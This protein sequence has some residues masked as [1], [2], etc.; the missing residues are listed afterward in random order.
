MSDMPKECKRNRSWV[1]WNRSVSLA[2]AAQLQAGVQAGRGFSQLSAKPPGSSC[3]CIL[4]YLCSGGA[5]Q[6][7]VTKQSGMPCV[8]CDWE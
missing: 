2:K 1:K 5:F 3:P 6:S 4:L 8:P 7:D